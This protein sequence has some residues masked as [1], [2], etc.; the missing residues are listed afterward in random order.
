MKSFRDTLLLWIAVLY[1]L[2]SAGNAERFMRYVPDECNIP[3]R[4]PHCAE[5][6]KRK[7]FSVCGIYEFPPRLS[8]YSFCFHL[9]MQHYAGN[10]CDQKLPSLGLSARLLT[11]CV[12]RC[13]RGRQ[14]LSHS[15]DYHRMYHRKKALFGVLLRLETATLTTRARVKGSYL[16]YKVDPWRNRKPKASP[17][18]PLA[19]QSTTPTSR[20]IS[21]PTPSVS[22]SKSLRPVIPAPVVVP[23]EVPRLDSLLSP[24]PRPKISVSPSVSPVYLVPP[25]PSITGASFSPTPSASSTEMPPVE[26]PDL[27]PYGISGCLCSSCNLQGGYCPAC[28]GW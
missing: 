24:S 6:T 11:F 3:S 22:P 15:R 4:K 16:L 7:P 2:H 10:Y 13:S 9:L 12:L 25:V 17:L 28:C 19:A 21:K 1:C 8:C 18:A 23:P 20:P 5:V 27:Q 14:Q 26:V